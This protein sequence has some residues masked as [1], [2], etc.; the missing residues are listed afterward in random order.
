M[1]LNSKEYGMKIIKKIEPGKLLLKA[2]ALYKE[3]G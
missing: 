2:I 1:D 3:H